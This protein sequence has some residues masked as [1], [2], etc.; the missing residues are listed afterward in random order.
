MSNIVKEGQNLYDFV[1]Q[2]FGTLENLFTLIVDN[3]L[4]VNTKLVSGQVL[5]VNNLGVGDEDIKS[6]VKLQ[7]ITFS[8]DQGTGVTGGEC[9]HGK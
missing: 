6:F 8:N 1:L 7:G 9:T 5:I 2:E 3:D 4:N